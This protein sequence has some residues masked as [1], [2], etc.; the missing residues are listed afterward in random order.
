MNSEKDEDD[1]AS[2]IRF[3][4]DG[5]DWIST[6]FYTGRAELY[7]RCINDANTMLGLLGVCDESK[8]DSVVV[9]KGNYFT[10]KNS[11][12]IN[13]SKD[14]ILN[15]ELGACK[16]S[17]FGSK[18]VLNDTSY[19]CDGSNSGW[20][21]STMNEVLGE[22][23]S[24]NKGELKSYLNITYVCDGSWDYEWS[25]AKANDVLPKCTSDKNT[26]FEEYDDT[27]YVCI[28]G[29]WEIPSDVEMALNTCTDSSRG[30]IKNVG[31]TAQYV[32]IN[33][34]WRPLNVVEKKLGV[35]PK[36]GATG[37]FDGITFTC[38]AKRVLWRGTLNDKYGVVA[39]DSALWFTENVFNDQWSVSPF[40]GTDYSTICP[41]GWEITSENAWNNLFGYANKYGGWE[42]FVRVD[43]NSTTNFYGLNLLQDG[44]E[45]DYWL[46][47]AANVTC[48]GDD[49]CSA[50]AASISETSSSISFCWACNGYASAGVCTSTAAIR[51]VKL[52]E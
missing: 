7:V 2:A 11:N 30:E 17:L 1:Y 41:A 43:S 27:A 29:V 20:R 50:P 26:D 51:C 39:V 35:C 10:C 49:I 13:S 32:C 8:D 5:E 22:C 12:W 14:E 6:R 4:Y 28:N 47:S 33:R 31:D 34:F 21:M 18:K 9:Y 3:D 45:T 16:T 44:R 37:V 19:T 23:S 42:A 25:K 38:D 52:E 48:S 15:I 40:N 24:E 36:N 46:A